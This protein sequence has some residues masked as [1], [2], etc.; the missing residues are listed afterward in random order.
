MVECLIRDHGVVGFSLTGDI[1]LSCT[2]SMT[3]TPLLNNG[4]VQE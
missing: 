3:L 4:S 1:V 2:L